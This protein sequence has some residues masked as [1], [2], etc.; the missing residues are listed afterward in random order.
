MHRF[1]SCCDDFYINLNLNTEMELKVSRESVMHFFEQVRKRYPTMRN[2]YGRDH[3]DHV[4][5]EN[6][7]L[8]HYRWVSVE[9]KRLCAGF[10]NP[11]SIDDAVQGREAPLPT[12]PPSQSSDSRSRFPKRSR[13]IRWTAGCWSCSPRPA[14]L[15]EA[16]PPEPSALSR[17]AELAIRTSA[18]WISTAL[19][20]V[21]LP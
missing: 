10:V 19:K 13:P 8:G 17:N 18:C 15:S 20:P 5:E 14:R 9:R 4:L 7:E 6:K 1:G 3:G 2:F 21:K 16:W 12:A 11:D